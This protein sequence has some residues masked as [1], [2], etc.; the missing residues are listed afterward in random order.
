MAATGASEISVTN[1]AAVVPLPTEAAICNFLSQIWQ[2]DIG[3]EA[4]NLLSILTRAS[5][6][7]ARQAH[8]LCRT[9]SEL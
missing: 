8:R 5:A 2:S 4:F 7:R 9:F 3:A 6:F 1:H